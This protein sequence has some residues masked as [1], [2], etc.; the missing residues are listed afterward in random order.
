MEVRIYRQ[1]RLETDLVVHLH[2]EVGGQPDRVSDLGIRLSTPFRRQ[3]LA[4]Q[5]I[6]TLARP[7]DRAARLDVRG[8]SLRAGPW[9]QATKK[10]RR[11][12]PDRTG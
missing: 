4:P 5:S 1:T 10:V 6:H 12:S 11:R 9:P 8:R 2:R 3:G 7:A